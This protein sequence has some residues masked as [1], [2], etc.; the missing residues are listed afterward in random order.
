[1]TIVGSFAVLLP[2]VV[3]SAAVTVTE[4]VAFGAFVATSTTNVIGLESAPLAIAVVL[5]QV[6]GAEQ[7][8]PVP[9]SACWPKPLGRF[10]D[11]VIVSPGSVAAGPLLCTLIVYVPALVPALKFPV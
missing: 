8:Q 6:N 4:F 9:L 2:L 1:M 5:V 3:S 11:T 10:S 7:S